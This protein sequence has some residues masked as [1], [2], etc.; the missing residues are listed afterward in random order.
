MNNIKSYF[1]SSRGEWIKY[2]ITSLPIIFAAMVLSINSFI[3]NFMA[4]S[5]EGGNQA[6][7]YS[8]QWTQYCSGIISA[9]TLVGSALFGQYLGLG[10]RR[11]IRE[12]VRAR[13]LIALIIAL[14]FVIPAIS[15]PD[16]LIRVASGFDDQLDSK[17]VNTAVIYTR[18]ITISWI[19]QAWFYTSSMIIREAGYGKASL[20]ASIIS[21]GLNV[22]FNSIFT[23]VAHM[24]ILGLAIS[25]IISLFIP[26]LFISLFI[27]LKDK[28]LVI[29]PLKL[30]GVSKIIWGQIG[31]RIP[32]F[33]FATIASVC[34][35]TRFTFWNIGYKTGNVGT[36]P[37]YQLSAANLLGISGMFFNIFWNTFES[38]NA[39]VAIFVGRQL[40]DNNF[41]KA[42]ENAKQLQGFHLTFAFVMG[43][44]LFSLSFAVEKMTFLTEGYLQQLKSHWIDILGQ[45]EGLAKYS[46]LRPQAIKEYMEN[47][48]WTLWPLAWNMPIWIWYIT[49]SRIISGGGKTNVVSL[50]DAIANSTQIGWIAIINF[51]IVPHSTLAFP[52]AYAIFFLSDLLKIPCY[53]IMY[54]KVEWA[55]N[56]TI[57]GS[58]PESAI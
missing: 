8:N 45:D 46:Q 28:R 16:F 47:L 5:I 3:D 33:I 41:E 27:W 52:W 13:T 51:V 15:A 4:T 22:T 57:E 12:V 18:V 48:K 29:N 20:L 49:K 23:Y 39:N 40:G 38:V 9:T 7:S 35:T 53:E 37:D 25:T 54:R 2:T 34:V 36:N 50:F 6:L 26:V 58:K 44:L 30:F 11:K 31:R 43:A 55:R 32:T 24:G 21:L 10:D 1:P 56:V 14:I 17:I 19:L 42:K